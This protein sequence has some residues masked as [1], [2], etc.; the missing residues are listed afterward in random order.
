MGGA[1]ITLRSEWRRPDHCAETRRCLP[2]RAWPRRHRASALPAAA[3]GEKLPSLERPVDHCTSATLPQHRAAGRTGRISPIPLRERATRADNPKGGPTD[4]G[5]P[6]RDGTRATSGPQVRRRLTIRTKLAAA[7]A[8]PLTLLAAF[9]AMQVRGAYARGRSDQASDAGRKVGHGTSRRRERPR[10]RAQLP[11][12]AGH[13]SGTAGRGQEDHRGAD[14]RSYQP[15]PR[16]VPQPAPRSEQGRGR[17]LRGR[18]A[19]GQLDNRA[20]SPY[21]RKAR[22]RHLACQREGRERAVRRL[23]QAHRQ[24]PRRRPSRGAPDR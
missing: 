18:A 21:G 6:N 19:R 8:V 1:T 16:H 23:Q 11:I 4:S 13:R 15:R 5:A 17:Q 3:D 20:D 10:E 9:A 12:V 24:V 7:L 14:D 22:V 2:R